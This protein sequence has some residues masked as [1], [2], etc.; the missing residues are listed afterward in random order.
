MLINAIRGHEVEVGVTVAKGPKQVA[1][2]LQHLASA[3]GV[4][5][6]VRE[7]IGVLASQLDE[8][9]LKLKAIGKRLMVWHR[10]DQTSQCLTTIPGSGR[11]AG[12]ASPSKCRMPRPIARADTLPPGL[13]SRRAKSRPPGDSGSAG[14]VARAM[15]TCGARW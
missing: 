10:Q 1:E 15:R 3:E 2:L 5:A 4:P 6:L 14:S 12:S 9:D 7:M 13:A 11:S 8:L